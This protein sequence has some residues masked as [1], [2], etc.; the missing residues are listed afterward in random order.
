MKLTTGIYHNKVFQLAKS[1][2][3]SHRVCDDVNKKTLK[4]SQK[5]NCLS[6]FRPFLNTSKNCRISDASSCL[7]SLVKNVGCF[8]EVLMKN[9]AKS[10]LK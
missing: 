1:F 6:Q 4:R 8:W 5:I 3:V 7:S 2:G 10:S 9:P